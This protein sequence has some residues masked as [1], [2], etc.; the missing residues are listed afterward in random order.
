M[1]IRTGFSIL[2]C[3]I[4]SFSTPKPKDTLE[5]LLTTDDMRY[6]SI[7]LYMVM[8]FSYAGMALILHIA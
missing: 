5:L 8:V 4:C 7:Y 2:S 3:E 6:L 1:R